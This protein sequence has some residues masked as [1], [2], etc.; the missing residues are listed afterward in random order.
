MENFWHGKIAKFWF[1][2]P[3]GY[4]KYFRQF[5]GK[6]ICITADLV[7][8]ARILKHIYKKMVMMSVVL[9]FVEE[10]CHLPWAVPMHSCKDT[11]PSFSFRRKIYKM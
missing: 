9:Y 4:V 5:T 11:V 1:T 7:G 8:S 10:N 3:L 2:N 6:E